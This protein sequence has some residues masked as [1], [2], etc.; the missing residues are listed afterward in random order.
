[1]EQPTMTEMVEAVRAHAIKNY[2]KKGGWDII[3]EC[4]EE[5]E[6]IEWI[7]KAKTIAGAIRNVAEKS[8]IHDIDS[9]R[10]DIQAEA[11]Y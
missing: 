8:G 2:E 11:D 10:R 7:G 6:I 1:M 5:N 3:I 4:H 9:Y